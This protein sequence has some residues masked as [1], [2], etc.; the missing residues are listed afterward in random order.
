[1]PDKLAIETIAIFYQPATEGRSC[2]ICIY[3]EENMATGL[4]CGLHDLPTRADK[5]CGQG[6]DGKPRPWEVKE[7]QI[8]LF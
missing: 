3:H 7:T 8:D 1:M 4:H 2:K 5:W 6:N